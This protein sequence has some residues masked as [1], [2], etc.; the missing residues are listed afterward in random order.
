[1]DEELVGS[2]FISSSSFTRYARRRNPFHHHA[3]SATADNNV[4]AILFFCK[5]FSLSEKHLMLYGESFYSLVFE[6]Q[7]YFLQIF[8]IIVWKFKKIMNQFNDVIHE[9]KKIN[10]TLRNF[11]LKNKNDSYFKIKLIDRQDSKCLFL[12]SENQSLNPCNAH[13]R[14]T[15]FLKR[16][17]VSKLNVSSEQ[18]KKILRNKRAFDL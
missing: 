17:R 8:L 10:Q 13:I 16:Y 18:C 7:D 3:A 5:G 12:T 2:R 11:Q 15:R 4:L 9:T 6:F 14:K 1:M